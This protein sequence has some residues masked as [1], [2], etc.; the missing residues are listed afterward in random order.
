[1]TLTQ[2]RLLMG[3]LGVFNFFSGITRVFWKGRSAKIEE[4]VRCMFQTV[5]VVLDYL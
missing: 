3:F 1:M 2:L 5:D 4:E